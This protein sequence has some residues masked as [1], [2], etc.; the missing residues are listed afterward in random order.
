MTTQ[1]KKTHEPIQDLE[2]EIWK[3]IVG[4][5]GYYEVSNKGRV[6]SLRN[7]IILKQSVSKN[8]YYCVRLSINNKPK[9]FFVHQVVYET[10]IGKRPKGHVKGD[11]KKCMVINHKDENP[12]NNCAENLEVISHYEN[13]LYGTA[14][15]R[16]IDKLSTPL[17]QYSLKGELIRH[18]QR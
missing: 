11:S 5:E 9:T 14:K 8:G 17:Y 7:N 6:K 16:Q 10:F 2:G 18:W 1:N 3:P 12:L 13:V 15:Q 4:Y